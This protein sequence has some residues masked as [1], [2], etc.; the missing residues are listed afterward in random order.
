MAFFTALSL[1]RI[2]HPHFHPF[3]HEIVTVDVGRT[4]TPV[5]VAE[6]IWPGFMLGQLL[7]CRAGVRVQAGTDTMLKD[8]AES[9]TLYWAYRRKNRPYQDLSHGWGSNSQWRT[10]FRRD[11]T[12]GQSYI[13]NTDGILDA[14]L[15]DR[16]ER[17]RDD[18]SP[19][20]RI[21]LL[22]NRC[23]V[24]VTAHLD[25]GKVEIYGRVGYGRWH[26]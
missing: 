16:P 21:E 20:E 22:V 8:V 15:P 14:R 6:E 24:R 2:D 7:F 26:G 17:W 25:A 1:E 19:N 13:Y 23:F 10:E 5:T 11:Y 4:G 18:L 12:D 9:S 3:Y